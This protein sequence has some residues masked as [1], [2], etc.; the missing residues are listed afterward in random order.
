MNV[1]CTGHERDWHWGRTKLALETNAL[2]VE[3]S[4]CI[5]HWRRK[6]LALKRKRRAGN[7]QFYDVKYC[8]WNIVLAQINYYYRCSNILTDF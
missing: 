2:G 4:E 8:P 6:R 7:E 3:T 5:Y 1:F